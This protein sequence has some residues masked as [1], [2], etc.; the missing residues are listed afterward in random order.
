[1]RRY[2]MLA[3]LLAR[4]R[5]SSRRRGF[6]N[7]RIWNEVE[8]VTREARLT[9]RSA[10]RTRDEARRDHERPLEIGRAVSRSVI[11]SFSIDF[12]GYLER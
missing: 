3:K 12:H 4:H 11:A 2:V 9:R 8:S 10:L 5:G 1:M 7:A 6:R